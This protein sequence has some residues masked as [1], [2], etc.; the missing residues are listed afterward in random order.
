VIGRGALSG[1][2]LGT[3]AFSGAFGISILLLFSF[4]DSFSIEIFF[5]AFK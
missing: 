5:N 3:G 4:I 1:G 2:K